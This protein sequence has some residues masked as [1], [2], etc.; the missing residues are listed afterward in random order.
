MSSNS[1]MSVMG[2]IEF[3]LVAALAFLFWR[4][5]AAAPFP[6]DGAL[7]GAARCFHSSAALL[8]FA[9]QPCSLAAL[10][11]PTSYVSWAVYIASAVILFFIM[12]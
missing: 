7:F 4:R 6:R 2:A 9:C 8:L 12:H 3:L 11:M 10:F 5:K 1:A